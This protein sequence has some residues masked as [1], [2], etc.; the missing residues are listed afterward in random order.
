MRLIKLRK[1]LT[2]DKL[3]CWWGRSLAKVTKARIVTMPGTEWLSERIERKAFAGFGYWY[4]C[5]K[6]AGVNYP[7][8]YQNVL[9]ETGV[10]SHDFWLQIGL[11][12]SG[13]NQERWFYRIG[14]VLVNDYEHINLSTARSMQEAWFGGC[15]FSWEIMIKPASDNV[16]I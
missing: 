2:W 8:I 4:S 3:N 5:G 7:Q 14:L 12:W 10:F 6:P 9:G 15:K 11:I 16:N 13:E 1:D